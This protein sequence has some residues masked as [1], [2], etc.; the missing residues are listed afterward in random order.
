MLNRY[1]CIGRWSK[2]IELTA[3]PS[4]KMVANSTI[5][6]NERYGE[7]EN[8]TFLPVVMWGKTAETVAE[9][10]G[11]GRLISIEGRIQTRDYENNEGRRIY[12]TEVVA[13]TVKF[14]EKKE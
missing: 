4:G 10:S 3:T 7:N 14:L 2:D 9:Y 5:A 1:V 12:I 6:I 11:K 13:E 8:T